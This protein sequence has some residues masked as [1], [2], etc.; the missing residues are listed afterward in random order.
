MDTA[1]QRRLRSA[2]PPPAYR[3]IKSNCFSAMPNTPATMPGLK[4][5]LW[6]VACAAFFFTGQECQREW[7]RRWP[8]API[9]TRAHDD[10]YQITIRRD[11]IDRE[12]TTTM[13][14]WSDGRIVKAEGG[15]L[16][17]WLPEDAVEISFPGRARTGKEWRQSEERYMLPRGILD[18]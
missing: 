2:A 6:L 14:V 10:G 18:R 7:D 1:V 5:M 15:R 9:E 17:K 4:T 12:R 16:P 8:P 3:S 11:P 13:V